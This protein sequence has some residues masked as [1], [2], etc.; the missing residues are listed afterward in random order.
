VKLDDCLDLARLGPGANHLKQLA[1]FVPLRLLGVFLFPI[2][3]GS[4]GFLIVPGEQGSQKVHAF[5]QRGPH[6]LELLRG[7]TEHKLDML[8]H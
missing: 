2:T 1:R 6:S 7:K 5:A 4:F 8:I 3:I